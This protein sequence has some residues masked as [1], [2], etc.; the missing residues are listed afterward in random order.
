[1]KRAFTIFPTNQ[2][3]DWAQHQINNEQNLLPVV[4]GS[5][6]DQQ[7]PEAPGRRGHGRLLHQPRRGGRLLHHTAD[8]AEE[9]RR[10]RWDGSPVRARGPRSGG[11]GWSRRGGLRGVWFLQVGHVAI[12]QVGDEGAIRQ[13][14]AQ[15]VHDWG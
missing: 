1:M 14:A 7:D 2:H 6:D 10:L 11:W 15:V 4:L 12:R 3:N 8:G 13:T 5:V 9:A